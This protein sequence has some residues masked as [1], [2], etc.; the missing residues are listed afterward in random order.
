MAG[1]AGRLGY[2]EKGKSI[3]Y[4]E[5]PQDRQMLFR[6]YVRG[7]LEPL[8][9]SFNASELDTWAVRLLAQIG[10]VPKRD[11][12]LLLLNTYGGYLAHRRDPSWESRLRAEIEGLLARMLTLGLVEEEL[13]DVR[14]TLLGRACG[15]S[16]LSFRSAMRLVDLVRNAGAS[17][18]AQEL[19]AI[20]QALPEADNTWTP[21]MKRGAGETIRPSQAAQRL[22]TAIVHMLQRYADDNFGY[23][24]RCKR[25]A[26]LVDWVRGV[27]IEMIEQSYSPNPYQGRISYGDVRRFADMTRFHLR[28]AYKITNV[29]FLSGGPGQE[30]IEQ[31]LTQLEE[32]LPSEALPLL[33]LPVRLDRGAYLSLHRAGARTSTDVWAMADGDIITL[34]GS[35]LGPTLI[36]KRPET[37]GTSSLRASS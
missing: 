23:L 3:I 15:E 35:L 20:V 8:Q 6:K 27:S 29:L 18:T 11:V 16:S 4:A 34:V 10:S 5:T 9:S 13:G 12:A 1:R 28:P 31:L 2:N 26:I 33:D 17:V 7:A 25:A 14:L 30:S 32:G 36:A 37:S 22:S 21:L 19:M 24:A